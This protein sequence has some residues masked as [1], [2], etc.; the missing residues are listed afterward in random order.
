M[1]YC[2]GKVINRVSTTHFATEYTTNVA[3]KRARHVKKKPFLLVDQI[4]DLKSET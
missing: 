1:F 3:I 2:D 4:V